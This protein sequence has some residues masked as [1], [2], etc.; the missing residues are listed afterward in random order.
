VVGSVSFCPQGR[1]LDWATLRQLR[2]ARKKAGLHVTL[3][4]EPWGSRQMLLSD[5]KDLTTQ[6]L[7]GGKGFVSLVESEVRWQLQQAIDN[8][9]MPDHLDSHQHVHVLPGIW[10]TCHRLAIEA[11]IPRVR[12]PACPNWRAMKRTPA[13]LVLQ[14]LSRLR[15][16]KAPG[17]LPCIGLASA[18]HNTASI[19]RAEL[20]ACEGKDVEIV[21]H[22][23]VNTP[24]LASTY[25]WGFDWTG[26]RDALLSDDFR[27]TLALTGYSLGA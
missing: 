27:R 8:G 15:G 24:E 4:G 7:T 3:V 12:V 11:G 2:A 21:V 20:A 9:V 1:S 22:P 16:G 5:W 23:G 26:E 6:L 25:D 14:G 18:G 13:G 10:E 19:L 17:Y